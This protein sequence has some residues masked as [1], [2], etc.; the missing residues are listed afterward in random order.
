MDICVG[1]NERLPLSFQ[2][3]S[4]RLPLVRVTLVESYLVHIANRKL[5]EDLKVIS[6]SALNIYLQYVNDSSGGH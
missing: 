1:I 4:S 2:T 3:I 5:S 6:T